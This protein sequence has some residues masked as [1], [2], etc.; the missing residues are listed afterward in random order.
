MTT[1]AVTYND[2]SYVTYDL[3]DEH[4]NLLATAL[5]NGMHGI[6]LPDFGILI[7]KDIRAVVKQAP[8]PLENESFSP[9]MTE[10]EK[11]HLA[12]M[13]LATELAKIEYEDE[14]EYQGGMM[15]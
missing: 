15:P 11:E 5:S 3:T 8:A 9:D 2:M 10:E 13:K 1:Y 12:Y 7:T 6:H 4:Y 14:T